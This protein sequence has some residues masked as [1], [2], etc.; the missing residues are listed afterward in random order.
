MELIEHTGLH[1]LV[2]DAI[3][4]Y[5]P[6]NWLILDVNQRACEMYGMQKDELVG[7]S[8]VDLSASAEREERHLRTVVSEGSYQG[9]ETVHRRN[10]GTPIQ[11]RVNSSLNELHGRRAILSVYRNLTERKWAEDALKQSDELYRSVVEQAAE[12][13][14]VVEA[15]TKRI[16]ETNPAFRTMLGYTAEELKVMTLYDV[17]AHSR[18]SVDTNTGRILEE[19]R[20]FIG[21]R[22]YRRKDGSLVDVEVSVSAIRYGGVEAMCVVA[23]DATER[24]RTERVLQESEVKYRS[25]V[26]H[27][28]AI[29]YM[30]APDM[31][32]PEW[33]LLYVSP[34]VEDL[35]GYTPEEW[36][37]DATLWERVLHPDD[38][39][40]ALAEDARTEA[41]GEPFSIEC[42]LIARDGRTVWV[43]DDAVLV[44]DSEGRPLFWQGI[45]ID[46]TERREIEE[47]L[48]QAE[49]KYRTL[50]EQIPAMVYIEDMKGRMTTLYDSPQIE[51]M[52]GY[53]QNTHE[54]NPDYWINIIH[55]DDRKRVLAED[56][57]TEATGERFSQEYRVL[58]SDGRTV[59]VRDDAVLVRDEA[60]VPVTWQGVIYDIT[61]RKRAE[62]EIRRLNESLERRV[63][64]RTAQL[65]AYA[66]RLRRSNREL[67]DFAHVA[68]HDLQEPLRKVLTFGDRLKAKYSDALDEQGR[69]Y[70]RR[71][72]GAAVRMQD[73]IEDLL[74]LSRVTTRA[75]PFDRVDLSEV[76]EEVVSDL[77]AVIEESGGRVELGVLPTVDADRPQ[78]RQLFQNLIGNALKFHTEGQVP[79]V[80]VRGEVFEDRRRARSKSS[81]KNK[82]CRIT[83]EDNGIGFDEEHLERIFVPFQRLHGR[84][85]YEGTGMGLAICRKVV[86]RHGGEITAHSASGQGATFVVT[87]PVE[88]PDR[89]SR[90]E[91]D[92][93]DNHATVG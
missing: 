64:E 93:F 6:E 66:E 34:Q 74:T 45:M 32:E 77:E 16:L 17:V 49:A 61:E 70:L 88:Q 59:W 86:E 82:V 10:D 55:P 35:L 5:D 33:N 14:F 85:V 23:H 79:V 29:T 25:L 68:S 12:N 56:T 15:E 8:V 39:E 21:E 92:V 27:I 84:N 40:H 22:R 28:P 72:E 80:K 81:A 20:H 73:L 54:N 1:E 9:F 62:E 4:V 13:I 60:G 83:V 67:Q 76:A 50:V 78:I 44:R 43:R 58:G 42:R 52:L 65:E 48:R 31:G 2:D 19:G 36:T 24:K 57:R 90:P 51:N 71:I 69:D 3:L 11:V 38:R 53:P 75:L 26:E 91:R 41:T 30:E 46:V 37:S 7:R 89:V 87:L 47:E 63:D 18:E